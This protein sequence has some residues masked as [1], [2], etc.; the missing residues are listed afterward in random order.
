MGELDGR[1]YIVSDHLDG[2]SLKDWLHGKRYGWREAV[3]I[4]AKLADAL[5]HAHAQGTVHRDVK[6]SNVMMLPDDQPVLIDFGLAISDSL[7]E[8]EAP[9]TVAGTYDFMSPEQVLGESSSDRWSNRH[10]RIGRCVVPPDLRQAP[11]HF[12]QHL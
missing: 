5:A 6:P 7:G 3:E 11:V 9:G 4:V 2:L 8:R 1:C 12:R 10:L